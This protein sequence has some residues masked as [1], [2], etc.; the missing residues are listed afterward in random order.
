MLQ[1]PISTP[2]EVRSSTQRLLSM[3]VRRI[4][5]QLFAAKSYLIDCKGG[6]LP[7]EG[8]PADKGVVKRGY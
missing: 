1:I 7:G 8:D 5:L 6:F 2:H 3:H 4:F